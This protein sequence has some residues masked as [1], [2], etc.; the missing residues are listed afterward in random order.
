VH[1]PKMIFCDGESVYPQEYIVP[2]IFDLHDGHTFRIKNNYQ[3]FFHICAKT[4]IV[5]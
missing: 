5:S 1:T 2:T 4:M 3:S